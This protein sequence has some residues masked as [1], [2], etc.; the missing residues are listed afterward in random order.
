MFDIPLMF[1]T[2]ITIALLGVALYLSVI[3]IE[4]WLVP[5]RG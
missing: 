3:S 1:A 2:L 5:S 4:R